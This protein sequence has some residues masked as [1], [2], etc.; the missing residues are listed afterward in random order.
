MK[1]ILKFVIIVVIVSIILWQLV[2]GQ[3]GFVIKNNELNANTVPTFNPML[4]EKDLSLLTSASEF[5]GLPDVVI[6]AWGSNSVNYGKTDTLLAQGMGNAGLE[7]NMCSKSCCSPQ[8]PSLSQP[9]LT[10]LFV[11]KTFSHHP[12]PATM[13]GKILAVFV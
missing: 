12:T 8:Y 1:E 9:K 3:E 11:A 6:P 7:F 2:Y 13:D 10:P 4:Y 5:V